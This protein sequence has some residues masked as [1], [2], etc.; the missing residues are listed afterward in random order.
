MLRPGRS[1]FGDPDRV[2]GVHALLPVPLH[3]PHERLLRNV[4]ASAA[5]FLHIREHP[6]RSH[7]SLPFMN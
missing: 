5:G 1:G 4:R 3:L 2:R 6:I 7:F